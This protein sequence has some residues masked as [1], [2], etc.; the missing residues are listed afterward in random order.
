MA[1]RLNLAT[2]QAGPDVTA[3]TLSFEL[4]RS[5][6]AAGGAAQEAVG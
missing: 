6:A 5:A 4:L 2:L 1:N 3:Q